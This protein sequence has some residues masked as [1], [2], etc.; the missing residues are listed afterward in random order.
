M[1][2]FLPE[3]WK[4]LQ[5]DAYSSTDCDI[6]LLCHTGLAVDTKLSAFVLLSLGLCWLLLMRWSNENWPQIK[7]ELFLQSHPNHLKY[8]SVK[9]HEFSKSVN[10]VK[11][12]VKLLQW[13]PCCAKLI[14]VA[15]PQNRF[16]PACVGFGGFFFSLRLKWKCSFWRTV[17]LEDASHLSLLSSG[18]RNNAAFTLNSII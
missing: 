12:Q 4:R 10:D 1:F 11:W 3:T 15:G 7:T 14:Y 5:Q 16:L 6:L 8:W 13:K 2:L 9:P 17:A 18:A